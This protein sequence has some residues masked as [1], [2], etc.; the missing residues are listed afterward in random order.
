MVDRAYGDA[1]GHIFQL[2]VPFALIALLCMVLIREAPLRTTV[3][4]A[5]ELAERETTAGA[6]R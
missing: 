3:E 4:R 5:D 6:A 1:I 2:A